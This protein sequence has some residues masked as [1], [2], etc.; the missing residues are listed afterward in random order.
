[1]YL[2]HK[3]QS[4]IWNN[5]CTSS[6][7]LS[8]PNF[9]SSPIQS[10][11]IFPQIEVQASALK[12]LWFCFQGTVLLLWHPV[13]HSIPNVFTALFSSLVLDMSDFMLWAWTAVNSDTF[14]PPLGKKGHILST[15][16]VRTML[17]IGFLSAE[18]WTSIWGKIAGDWIGEERKLGW[19]RAHEEVHWLF[20]MMLCCLWN[21]YILWTRAIFSEF[22]WK[23]GCIFFL[24]ACLF[25]TCPLWGYFNVS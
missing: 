22:F 1:M 18:A 10:P 5:Q 21:K 19:E 9:L 2:F 20:Q 17:V 8:H 6:C 11:A 23:Q 25:L 14:H 15:F 24:T 13:S 12:K 4:I 7:A 3:Q 16:D